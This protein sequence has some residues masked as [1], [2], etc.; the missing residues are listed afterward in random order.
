M[1]HLNHLES[2]IGI[3]CRAPW[4]GGVLGV[5]SPKLVGFIVVLWC[6]EVLCIMVLGD[7][8][9]AMQLSLEARNALP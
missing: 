8:S 9:L 4:E 1:K 3:C 2:L 7:G 6:L 5:S